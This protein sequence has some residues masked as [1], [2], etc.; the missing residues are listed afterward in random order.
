M[1]RNRE[2]VSFFSSDGGKKE[3]RETSGGGGLRAW[4]E[5]EIIRKSSFFEV[6]LELNDWGAGR[7]L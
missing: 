3:R 5:R 1:G 2:Y 4:I 6:G 7:G